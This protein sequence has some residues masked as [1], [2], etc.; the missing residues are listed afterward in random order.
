MG[1]FRGFYGFGDTEN[2][3]EGGAGDTLMKNPNFDHKPILE[4]DNM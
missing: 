3:P 1:L 4:T 2:P